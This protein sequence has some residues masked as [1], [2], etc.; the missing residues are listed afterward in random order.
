MSLTA[1]DFVISDCVCPACRRPAKV[2]ERNGEYTLRCTWDD[3]PLN[4]NMAVPSIET[5]YKTIEK[6]ENMKKEVVK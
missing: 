6:Y 3:C 2:Y 5:F 4:R 1:A